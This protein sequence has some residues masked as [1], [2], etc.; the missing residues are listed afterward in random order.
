ME[1]GKIPR[2]YLFYSGANYARDT[3][4]VGVA[5]SRIGSNRP[6]SKLVK[7]PGN[8]ILRGE[9]NDAFCG[10][11]HQDVTNVPG[12]GWLLFYH[13]YLGGVTK[14]SCTGSKRYLMMDPLRWDQPGGPPRMRV[15]DFWPSVLNRTPSGTGM[16]SSMEGPEFRLP[17]V[18]DSA[19]GHAQPPGSTAR[20]RVGAVRPLGRRTLRFGV[21]NSTVVGAAGVRVL[22]GPETVARSSRTVTLGA[23]QEMLD[24]PLNRRLEPGPYTAHLAVRDANGGLVGFDSVN[25]RVRR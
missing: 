25:L 18:P 22:R 4:A 17:P 20:L 7:Y 23:K 9:G 12:D 21:R 24:V 8:P 5:A 1:A 15:S 6:D 10:V 11:G 14:G 13:A 19:P 3:Y 16:T 2:Y